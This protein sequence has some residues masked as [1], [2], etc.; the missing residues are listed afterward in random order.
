MRKFF[1]KIEDFIDNKQQKRSGRE[2]FEQKIFREQN[3]GRK[4]T[5]KIKEDGAKRFVVWYKPPKQVLETSSAA[6]YRELIECN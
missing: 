3:F 2:P 1:A 5:K 4:F 6:S